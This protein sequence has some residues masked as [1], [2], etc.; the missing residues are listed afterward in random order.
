MKISQRIG[1]MDTY[2][3]AKGNAPTGNRT[4]GK[5]LEGIYVTTTPSAPRLLTQIK[6]QLMDWDGIA[7]YNL[8]TRQLYIDVEPNFVI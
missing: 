5:C 4:Q 2:I 3:K 1:G 8:V 7:A 6:C